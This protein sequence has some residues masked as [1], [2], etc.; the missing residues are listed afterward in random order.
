MT[1]R[2]TVLFDVTSCSLVDVHRRSEGAFCV[3]F[4]E[5][6][7]SMFF[8]LGIYHT[9]RRNV[10]ENSSIYGLKVF[11]KYWEKYIQERKRT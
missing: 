4:K 6:W 11:E 8:D 1:I 5:D 9:R 10:L 2:N 7:R 3:H